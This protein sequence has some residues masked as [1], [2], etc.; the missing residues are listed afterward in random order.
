MPARHGQQPQLHTT[1]PTRA[2]EV[3][4][5]RPAAPTESAAASVAAELAGVVPRLPQ[6]DLRDPLFVEGLGSSVERLAIQQAVWRWEGKEGGGE[7]MRLSVD[8]RP[9]SPRPPPLPAPPAV[10]GKK[11]TARPSSGAMLSPSS[12]KAVAPPRATLLR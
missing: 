5:E 12:G 2:L 8:G 1:P 11:T 4:S 3:H 7:G 10:H 9:G 6:P